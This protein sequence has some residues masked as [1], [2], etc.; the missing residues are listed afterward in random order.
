VVEGAGDELAGAVAA[1]LWLVDE[2]AEEHPAANITAPS[3][4]VATI[5]TR[6]SVNCFL[7]IKVLLL[8]RHKKRG[9][10]CQPVKHHMQHDRRPQ[11]LP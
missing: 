11:R 10:N 7:C 5:A 1:G 4:T 2:F 3:S 8:P 6:L 9:R